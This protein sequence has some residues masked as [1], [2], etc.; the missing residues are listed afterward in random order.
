MNRAIIFLIS[1]FLGIA[2][3]AHSIEPHALVIFGATGDLTQRKLIPALYTMHSAEQ[4][5]EGFVCVAVGRRDISTA[6]FREYVAGIVP[7]S[8]G[9]KTF[10]DFFH[11]CQNTKDQDL[12]TLKKFLDAQ[13]GT[14]GNRLFYLAT[15]ADLFP[16]LIRQLSEHRLIH[17]TGPWTRVIIEKP[18]G[19]DLETAQELQDV[20]SRYLD[21][22]QVYRIDHY[23]GKA[24]VEETLPLRNKNKWLEAI[25]SHKF[26][27]SVHITLSEQIGVGSRGEFW[28]KTGML[29]DVVQNHLMEVLAM[30]TLENPAT[31][32]VRAER[33]IVL[34]AVQSPETIVRAQYGP[35]K[36]AGKPVAG[37]PQ[38]LGVDPQSTV[39]T[40]VATTLY[41]DTPRW[42][43]VPFHLKAGKR[44]ESSFAQVLVTFKDGRV[45]TIRIQ[46]DP[47]IFI[48]D[49]TGKT[50]IGPSLVNRPDAYVRLLHESMVGNQSLFVGIDELMASWKLFTPILHY[51]KEHPATN[52]SNYPAG[53]SDPDC[54]QNL[55][56]KSLNLNS[57][58]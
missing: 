55:P 30:L 8:S 7:E 5:P 44:L 28:E 4:L 43:G 23:L 22:S 21:E 54:Y 12:D 10:L 51:W 1:L 9:K 39:E 45:L 13:T 32:T 46:P 36:I 38:E 40:Y 18:F 16:E 20:V 11:Y 14:Q 3:P 34:G 53:S 56:H 6:Q 33:A 15:A 37:Y 49:R 29:R 24:A 25:W 48:T 27:D 42:A 26:I 31:A 57:D 41:I 35:G 47:E 17:K 58:A 50:A 19:S 52:F 2:A